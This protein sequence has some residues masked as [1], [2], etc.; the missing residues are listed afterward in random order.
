MG[1]QSRSGGPEFVDFPGRLV[2]ACPADRNNCTGTARKPG[3][4]L[5]R[6]RVAAN[7]DPVVRDTGA[8][9]RDSDLRVVAS[10]GGRRPCRALSEASGDLVERERVP[11]NASRSW[12]NPHSRTVALMA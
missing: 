6:D 2:R 5:I 7:G 11:R 1:V 10:P 8:S 12:A 9:A 3:K 4:H